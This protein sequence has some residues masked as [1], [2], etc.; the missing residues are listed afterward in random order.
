MKRERERCIYRER[1]IWRYTEIGV[2]FNPEF[3]K[4]RFGSCFTS[5]D[6]SVRMR[7]H[8]NMLAV[9]GF[10]DTTAC[11]YMHVYRHMYRE[12]DNQTHYRK[13][14]MILAFTLSCAWTN[15]LLAAFHATRASVR[16]ELFPG[17]SETG[18]RRA[19]ASRRRRLTSATRCFQGERRLIC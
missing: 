7:E 19:P 11:Q 14:K 6:R 4:R 5:K 8:P 3:G 10:V 13:R 15:R 9:G 1:D 16:R 17:E 12:P 2:R 18:L